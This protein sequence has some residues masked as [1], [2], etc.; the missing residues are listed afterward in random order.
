GFQQTLDVALDFAD[1]QQT[2]SFSPEPSL[3]TLASLGK[4]YIDSIELT[5]IQI[6]VL[7]E[8]RNALILQGDVG[9]GLVN[10]LKPEDYFEQKVEERK[11]LRLSNANRFKNNEKWKEWEKKIWETKFPD[12]PFKDNN[13]EIGDVDE[14][15]EE[16]VMVEF[17]E[18]YFCPITHVLMKEPYTSSGCN[19]S[20][21]EAI[22]DVIKQNQGEVECPV[23][24][25]RRFVR[26]NML[27]LDKSLK[28][29]VMRFMATQVVEQAD[30]Q[31]V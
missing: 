21:S 8:L 12:K 17:H 15:D 14:R 22:F 1:L 10:N 29:R 28:R 26:M 19:H 30:Y 23:I 31:D 25:C 2:D 16:L 27:T 24:G 9:D 7:E 3:N 6:E 13:E 5:A 20:Y 4:S 18:N 11:Q